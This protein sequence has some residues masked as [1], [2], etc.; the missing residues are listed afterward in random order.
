MAPILLFATVAEAA[1]GL[2]LLALPSFVAQILFGGPFNDPLAIIAARVAG[3]ALLG[4]SAACGSGSPHLGMLVYSIGITLLLALVG[5]A[6][7]MAG[8]LLWPAVALHAVLTV[9][10]ALPYRPN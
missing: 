5:L 4:L 6:G 1:T 7:G 8:I 9:G 3:I 10:L 2:A